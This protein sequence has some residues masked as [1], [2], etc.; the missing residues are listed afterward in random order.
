MALNK[1]ASLSDR[2]KEGLSDDIT[3]TELAN[4]IGMSKQAISTYVTGIRVPNRPV[5]NAISE[6]LNINPMWLMGY[7]VKKTMHINPKKV[8]VPISDDLC[9]DGLGNIVGQ[10]DRKSTRLN[11]SH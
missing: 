5:I 9:S 4:K 3:V 1:V 2:L 10:E 6:V 8:N 7:D 11:S